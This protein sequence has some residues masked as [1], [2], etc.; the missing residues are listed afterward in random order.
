[1]NAY[2]LI[3]EI[4]AAGR[5]LADTYPF[6][7]ELGSLLRQ[8]QPARFSAFAARDPSAA[9]LPLDQAVCF[10]FL[11]SEE[12]AELDLAGLDWTLG[13]LID[14]GPPHLFAELANTAEWYQP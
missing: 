11:A 4:R 9:G 7:A 13:A 10:A 6:T 2:T 5:G 1:M 12:A 8:A 3:R 14:A